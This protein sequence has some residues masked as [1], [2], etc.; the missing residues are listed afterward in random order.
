MEGI[1]RVFSETVSAGYF[2]SA[3]SKYQFNMI[4]WS[5]SPPKYAFSLCWIMQWRNKDDANPKQKRHIISHAM[6]SSQYTSY[7]RFVLCFIELLLYS[8]IW[9]FY[10]EDF[11]SLF[12]W[13]FGLFSAFQ[14]SSLPSAG[15]GEMEA[16]T[17]GRGRNQCLL[18]ELS[19]YLFFPPNA[20]FW[21]FP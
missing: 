5:L 9:M 20:V 15:K 14:A 16:Q 8:F 7:S 4:V 11:S 13:L 12:L 17:G 2:R 3:T 19:W 1:L 21:V 6:S 10:C 18:L